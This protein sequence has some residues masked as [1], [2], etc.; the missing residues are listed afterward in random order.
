MFQRDSIKFKLIFVVSSITL[1]LICLLFVFQIY[2]AFRLESEIENSSI[3]LLEE[4]GEKENAVLL[5]QK[6]DEINYNIEMVS[7]ALS[8]ELYDLNFDSIRD[9]IEKFS[10]HRLICS[11]A[12][13][14][15]LSNHVVMHGNGVNLQGCVKKAQDILYLG[16]RVGRLEV[17]YTLAP[18]N[19]FIEESRQHL[20][21]TRAK[22][23]KDVSSL[24][25]QSILIQ[26][27]IYLFAAGLLV[28]LISDQINKSIIRPIYALMADMRVMNTQ[29]PNGFKVISRSHGND[30][31]GKLSRY[32]YDNIAVLIAQL[33]QRANYDSLTML[34]SRQLFI[35]D[36]NHT[37]SFNI[38]ILDID[39][40]KEINNCLGML[41]GDDFLRSTA[42]CLKHFY[43]GHTYNL[44][45]LNGDE[46]AIFDGRASELSIFEGHIKDFVESFGREDHQVNNESITASISAGIASSLHPNPIVSATIALKYAKIKRI[47]IASYRE[48]LP[49]LGEYQQNLKIAGIIRAATAHDL[50]T[51]YF[52]PIMDIRRGEIY[53]YEA[54]MRISDTD[55]RLY[56]PGEF[57]DVAKRTGNY[58]DL[59]NRLI[60]KAVSSFETNRHILSINLSI[61]DI[62]DHGIVDMLE[63]LQ[64]EYGTMH[65]L[66]FEITEQEGFS[67]PAKLK[68]FI[69]KAKQLGA[70]I[71]IDDFGSG[72]SNFESL[73]HLDIDYL[74]I[75]GSLIKNI[76]TDRNSQVVVETIIDFARKLNIKT[77]A[78]YVSSEAIYLK[79]AA[80]GVD[81]AQGYHIGKPAPLILQAPR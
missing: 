69:A 48:D 4:Y 3:R 20:L 40:F 21:D 12:V 18:F 71:A 45:R 19:T 24:T 28:R 61:E 44:Y 26:S 58:R 32:F 75:D 67:S 39:R 13:V 73:I 33:N 62:E 9:K 42:A 34:R 51:P 81:F 5:K 35:F 11:L 36:V 49:I 1:L 65:R 22:L 52:Q 80:M 16:N 64:M 56:T 29:E 14:D 23:R 2:N 59:S 46:F 66:I 60:R 8:R 37:K 72:Y 41:A 47:K 15:T 17:E 77:V 78:E 7:L 70:R 74:K 27:L 25:R 63:A 76:T 38:A 68:T 31:L 6:E 57:L 10:R 50:V 53:K 55:G 54:L 43:S 30:E 79:V